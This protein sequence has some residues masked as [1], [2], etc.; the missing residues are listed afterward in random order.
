MEL[1][2]AYIF[3]LTLSLTV[4]PM[5]LLIVQRAITKG[6]K[7]G[8]ATAFGLAFADWTLALIAFSVGTSIL[9]AINEHQIL[10]HIFSGTLLLILAL[11]IFWSAFK[12]YKS[13]HD[14][15]P[16]KATGRDFVSAYL[17]TVHNPLTIAIFL[18]FIGNIAGISSF[19]EIATYSFMVFIGSCTGQVGVAI[20]SHSMRGLFKKPITIFVLNLA[21]SLVIAGFGVSNVISA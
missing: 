3:G 9:F 12:S 6:F 7:S 1:L 21:S 17:L 10:F 5:T 15:K 18:G 8:L 16:P 14:I 20:A 13:K 11:Y 19:A 2:A 4:G